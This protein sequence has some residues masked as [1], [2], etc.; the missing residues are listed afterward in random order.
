MTSSRIDCVERVL[1]RAH[2]SNEGREGLKLTQPMAKQ[3]TTNFSLVDLYKLST[4]V[5]HINSR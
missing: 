4:I 3:S 2:R 5:E 1:R